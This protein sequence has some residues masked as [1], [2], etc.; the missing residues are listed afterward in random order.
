MPELSRRRVFFYGAGSAAAAAIATA[1]GL[2]EARPNFN[3]WFHSTLNHMTLDQKIGQLMVQEVYGA[4]PYT[5]DKRNLGQY[6]VERPVDV[7]RELHLG[8]VIYFA[9]TASFDNGPRGVCA[10]SRG[11]QE[12]SV[13]SGHKKVRIPLQISTDQEMGVVT[14]FG[15]PATQFP[16][17]M[18]LGA[19]RSPE[20]AR[21]AAAI[22]GKEL[23][24]VGINVNFAPVAD[25]NVDAN[26]PVI[27]V[28]SFGSDPQMVAEL[29][30]AQVHGYQEDGGVSTSPKHF[31]G[32]G[33]TSVDSHVGLP[34]IDHTREEWEAIDA[35]PFRAAIA[36]GSDMIMT[37]HIVVPV[38]D[39]SG[40]P[41]T[42]SKPIITG[43]LRNEL[44][45]DGVVITDGLMMAAVREKY[46]DAEVAV[47][48]L[49]AGCDQLLMLPKPLEARDAIKEAI[50]SGRLT[51]QQI[52]EKVRR[53]MKLKWDRGFVTWG[54]GRSDAVYCDDS[55]VDQIVGNPAHLREAASIT[56]RT[57]TVVRNEGD[58]LPMDVG[59][60]RVLVTG[61]GVTT[62]ANVAKALREAGATVSEMETG[63][64]PDAAKRAAVA[65]KAAGHDV[66]MVLTNNVASY[67][68]QV[69]LVEELMAT[70]TPVIAVAVRNP[71]DVAYFEATAEIATYSY[72][73]VMPPSLVRVVTGQVAPTGKLPVDVPVPGSDEVAYP[74][75][76]GLTW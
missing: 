8:G 1:P 60:K 59:G 27:G 40:D 16:G 54:R 32:H 52:D 49:E 25:V 45:Y 63:T 3:G 69:R 6:G 18:A 62:T 56:D 42:L 31:P 57:V 75:G 9:W 39:D 11:L 76:Y 30:E 67:P 58:L 12:A 70:G 19:G 71:Y 46:G 28:R 13:D 20:D 64:E 53:I 44:G 65:A 50:A 10:L 73:V 61:W 48:A 33:D 34:V 74:Y 66:V 41:A 24:A 38:F 55:L 15:P 68:D 17:S 43:V 2:A 23:L 26:N 5:P 4:D 7:I 47:R 22:T 35:P 51:E 72:S 29:V 21:R 37:A 36:A 14:R